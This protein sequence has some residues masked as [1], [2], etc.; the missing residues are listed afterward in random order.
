MKDGSVALLVYDITYPS[1]DGVNV[2][3]LEVVI[4]AFVTL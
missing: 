1:V 4:A 3:V 2:H